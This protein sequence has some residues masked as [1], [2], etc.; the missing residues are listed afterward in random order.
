[1]KMIKGEKGERQTGKR[2]MLKREN[3]KRVVAEPPA[4]GRL[5]FLVSPFF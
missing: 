2:S 5:I 3:K 4:D 1:M